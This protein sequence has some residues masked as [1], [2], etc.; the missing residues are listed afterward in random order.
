MWLQ[1]T[2]ICKPLQQSTTEHRQA[3]IERVVNVTRNSRHDLQFI[4][5]FALRKNKLLQRRNLALFS[6]QGLFPQHGHHHGE[7]PLH[8][9]GVLASRA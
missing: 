5:L 9:E 8:R 1:N 7:A 3:L 4:F 6:Y 2:H